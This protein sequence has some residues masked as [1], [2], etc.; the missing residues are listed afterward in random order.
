[1]LLISSAAKWKRKPQP[2]AA[3]LL[4]ALA[5]R[6]QTGKGIS[7]GADKFCTSACGEMKNST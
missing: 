1:M 6:A 4:F 2:A 5:R 3:L 7:F